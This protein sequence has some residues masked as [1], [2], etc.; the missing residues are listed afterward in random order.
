MN[1]CSPHERIVSLQSLG[2]RLSQPNA[3][4]ES[5]LETQLRHTCGPDHQSKAVQSGPA[6]PNILN[7]VLL[8]G[9]E[10]RPVIYHVG[11]MNINEHKLF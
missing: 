3:M 11:V 7:D 6:S 1:S 8:Y 2:G 10:A 9:D 5:Q 4:D